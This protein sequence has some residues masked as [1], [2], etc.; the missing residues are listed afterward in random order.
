MARPYS[1]KLYAL[2]RGE[3]NLCDG[4]IREIHEKTGL[5]LKYL[6]WMKSSSAK[7]RLA[8]CKKAPTFLVLIDEEQE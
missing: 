7:A 1:T 6:N 4:T 5:S 2:Y 3:E 8:K